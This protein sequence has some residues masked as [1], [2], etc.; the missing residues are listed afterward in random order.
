MTVCFSVLHLVW[1][2]TEE[3]DST[4]P[5]VRTDGQV[6]ERPGGRWIRDGNPLSG[7]L[8]DGSVSE[9]GHVNVAIRPHKLFERA[10]D[11][12]WCA[13][14]SGDSNV[15]KKR[16]LETSATLKSIERLNELRRRGTPTPVPEGKESNGT[17]FHRAS[18]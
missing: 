15:Y 13:N 10:V 11:E 5:R 8:Y 12:T 9:F 16:R 17:A 18:S 3:D 7:V 14:A 6:E 1:T 2:R 4:G